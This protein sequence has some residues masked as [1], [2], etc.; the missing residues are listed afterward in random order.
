M[1]YCFE[2]RFPGPALRCCSAMSISVTFI[3]LALTG[4]TLYTK[5]TRALGQQHIR[6]SLLLISAY[7]ALGLMMLL[8]RLNTAFKASRAVTS[9]TEEAVVV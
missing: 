1:P 5:W 7:A 9:L 4:I 6:S 3:G 2:S 8:L